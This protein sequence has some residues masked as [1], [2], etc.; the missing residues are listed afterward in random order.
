[1]APSRSL[2]AFVLVSVSLARLALA[3]DI[4]SA[5]PLGDKSSLP[6]DIPGA[7]WANAIA[8]PNATYTISIQGPNLTQPNWNVTP[9]V[10][11]V[12]IGVTADISLAG[13]TDSS[14]NQSLVFTGT[15]VN[16]VPG[17][18]MTAPKDA[19]WEAC[20]VMGLP[21]FIYN[22]IDTGEGDEGLCNFLS[23]GCQNNLE[24]AIIAALK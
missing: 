20:I 10:W 19:E 3:Q 1:M 18:D 4:D 11:N 13:T 6:W 23:L 22:G 12:S 5:Q 21:G 16:F 7:S 2:P 9:D 15:Q 8:H 17:F 14:L 24:A